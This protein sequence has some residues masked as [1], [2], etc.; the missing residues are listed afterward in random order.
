MWWFLFALSALVLILIIGL[1]YSVTDTKEEDEK[2][3]ELSNKI[4]LQS[5]QIKTLFNKINILNHESEILNW[6]KINNQ[7]VVIKYINSQMVLNINSVDIAILTKTET[8]FE[9]NANGFFESGGRFRF[10]YLPSVTMKQT[11]DFKKLELFSESL[12]SLVNRG[13]IKVEFKEGVK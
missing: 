6:M 5:K 7:N 10:Q 9:Y 12:Y 4:S 3:K 11:Q 2:T 13:I 1:F 8:D